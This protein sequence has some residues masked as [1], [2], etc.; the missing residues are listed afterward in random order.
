MLDRAVTPGAFHFEAASSVGLLAR[1]FWDGRSAPEAEDWTYHAACGTP[2]SIGERPRAIVSKD[3]HGVA[4]AAALFEIVYPL[5]TPLQGRLAGPARALRRCAPHALEWKALCVGSTLTE[6]ARIDVRRDLKGA[7][8]DAALSALIDG[9]ESE[10][11]RRAAAVV[12]FKDLAPADERRLAPLLAARRYVAVR[13]LPVATLDL[14][15]ARTPDDYLAKLSAATRKDIRRKL[16]SRAGLRI[17]HKTPDA[18]E[19]AAIAELYRD[20]QT[21]S[22]VRYGD[23]E[24]LPEGYFDRMAELGPDQARF[25]LYWAS[26]TLV[27]FNLLLLSPDR[28]IDKFIGMRYPLAKENNVY[29]VS[30]MENIGFALATGRR[31]LQTG[32]TAYVDKLRFGSELE[33]RTIW[34]KHRFQPLNAALRASAGLLAF[35]RWDPAL[36][37][38]VRGRGRAPVG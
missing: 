34:A 5:D 9:V 14:G 27:A 6:Q 33:P 30:W 8:R 1:A 18:A 16:R 25:V 17:E 2:S 7:H 11:R 21:A 22:E 3:L 35:D 26:D 20:T 12:A 31:H 10:A 28:V 15:P 38:R 32:Q 19:R 24:E 23:F 37:Q 29:V 13:S 36:R 4:A